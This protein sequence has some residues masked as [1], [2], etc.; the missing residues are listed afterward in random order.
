VL[1]GRIIEK[2]SGMSYYDYVRTRIY[3]QA[4][5]KSTASLPEN[6]N[7]PSRSLGYLRQ[8]GSWISNADT[9]P[10]RGMAAGGGYSTVGDL[11][12]FALALESGKLISK[13]MLA[14]ATTS[15]SQ[16]YGYGFAIQGT[17]ALRNFGHSGGAPGMSGDLRMFSESGYVVIAL[18]NFD[19]PAANRM[20]DFFVSRMP[21]V[22][23]PR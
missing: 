23:S 19:P 21:L 10:W 20:I 11:L 13:T 9:L 17:G 16:Q 12:R 14:Q 5:M 3:E 7:V 4:G 1:L 18:S 8:N 22:T 2:A 6:E 15:Q